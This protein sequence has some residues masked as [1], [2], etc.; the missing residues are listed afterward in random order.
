MRVH[1]FCGY[2]ILHSHYINNGLAQ[3]VYLIC[4]FYFSFAVEFRLVCLVGFM[5]YQ[6]L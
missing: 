1:T 3:A 4:D 5:A 2:S 6:P